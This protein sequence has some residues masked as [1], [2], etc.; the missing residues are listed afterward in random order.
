[1]PLRGG[2]RPVWGRG[3]ARRGAAEAVWEVRLQDVPSAWSQPCCD[4]HLPLHHPSVARAGTVPGLPAAHLLHRGTVRK[5]IITMDKPV[6]AA[7]SVQPHSTATSLLSYWL[8]IP[9]I[10][11]RAQR[12]CLQCLWDVFKSLFLISTCFFFLPISLMEM[13]DYFFSPLLSISLK[14]IA[15]ILWSYL[16]SFLPPTCQKT[17]A[18]CVV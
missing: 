10:Q 8:G 4:H 12:A 1:M 14:W 2:Q 13:K 11:R 6:I 3:E 18:V 5:Y 16:S 15:I 9:E 7:W 17:T